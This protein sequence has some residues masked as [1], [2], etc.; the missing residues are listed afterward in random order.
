MSQIKRGRVHSAEEPAQQ[1]LGLNKM[2]SLRTGMRQKTAGGKEYPMK[3]DHFI[4][5]GKYA[6]KFLEAYPEKTSTVH[7]VFPHIDEELV[8][9][10]EI[11]FRSGQTL[12]GRSNGYEYEI[13]S[14]TQ[15]RFVHYEAHPDDEEALGNI[16]RWKGQW[17]GLVVRETL[18]LRFVLVKVRG[19]LGYWQLATHGSKSS[20]PNLVGVFD[21]VKAL[22]QGRKEL[23]TKIPFEL[24]LSQE[25]SQL[26][27]DV[28]IFNV[29]TLVPNITNESLERA[30]QFL[31]NGVPIA[32]LLSDETVERMA[33][34]PP[35]EDALLLGGPE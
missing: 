33:L 17:P 18:T 3:L 32:G 28:R 25:R 20:I 5:D 12:V 6:P 8:C 13:W 11:E 9:L 26:P 35:A 22:C 27:G 29:L 30:A 15:N 34:K 19:I 10:Q 24:H 31:G 1:R 14:K 16:E 2:G 7:L 21:Q 4:A 23:F